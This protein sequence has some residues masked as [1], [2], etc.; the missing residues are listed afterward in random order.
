MGWLKKLSK[1]KIG[2]IAQ[3]V[4]TGG[5]NTVVRATTGKNITDHVGGGLKGGLT[6]SGA[7]SSALADK[8]GS[9]E[10]VDPAF[11]QYQLDVAQQLA[12]QAAGTGPSMAQAQ[13][14][15]ATDRTLGQTLGTVRAATGP[16]AAATARAA[17]SSGSQLLGQSGN[18][19][20]ILALEEQQAAQKAL[21]NLALQSRQQSLSGW[22]TEVGVANNLFNAENNVAMQNSSLGRDIFKAGLGSL[23][24]AGATYATGKMG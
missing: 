24:N 20:A 12:A 3:D 23:F 19:S 7:D 4:A 6:V 2:D 5:I 21:A 17:A 16:N 15:A 22:G 13:L 8:A 11:R 10:N 18:A 14:Q 1:S 9:W